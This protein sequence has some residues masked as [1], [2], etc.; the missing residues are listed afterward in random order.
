MAKKHITFETFKRRIL[1]GLKSAVIDI[2][3]ENLLMLNLSLMKLG[4][5][6]VSPFGNNSTAEELL[7]MV[8]EI[9]NR[10]DVRCCHQFAEVFN[11]LVPTWCKTCNIEYQSTNKGMEWILVES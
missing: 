10:C 9:V 11:D 2:H 1:N 5:S 4:Y 8:K 3:N 7:S 6:P